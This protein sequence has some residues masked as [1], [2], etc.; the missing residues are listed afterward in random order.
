[1]T[2]QVQPHQYWINTAT[3]LTTLTSTIQPNHLLLHND[4]LELYNEIYQTIPQ[5]EKNLQN[6][7]QYYD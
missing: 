1:M 4:K 6:N 2:P 5:P 7:Q 3:Y